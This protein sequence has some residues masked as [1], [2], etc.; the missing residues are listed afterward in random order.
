MFIWF[1][2]LASVLWFGGL[3]WLCQPAQLTR[4][5][6]ARSVIWRDGFFIGLALLL[7]TFLRLPSLFYNQELNPDESQLLT[8]ALTLLRDPVY[9][10][11]VD[12]TSIGPVNSYL[13]LLPHLAGLPIDYIAARL[14]GLLLIS[15]AIF[16]FFRSLLRLVSPVVSRLTLLPVLV[17]FGWTSHADFLHFSSELSSL[18]IITACFLLTVRVLQTPVPSLVGLLGLGLVA[19]LTPYCKLQALPVVG[20]MLITLTVWLCWRYRA[21]AVRWLAAAGVGFLLPTG[22]VFGLACWFG[23]DRYFVDYYFVGNL[24]TYT[25]IYAN[26]PLVQQGFMAKLWHFPFFL[27]QYTD[28]LL[29]ILIN[30]LLV[31]VLGLLAFR[32]NRPRPFGLNF[33]SLLVGLTAAG[34][35]W[36][37]ITPGTEFGHHLLLLV[38]PLGWVMALGLQV[39]AQQQPGS[40]MPFRLA[41]LVGA[42]LLVDML[43]T[44]PLSVS[45]G[46]H[47]ARTI[48][49]RPETT[50]DMELRQQPVTWLLARNRPLVSFPQQTQLHQS[51]VSRVVDTYAIPSDRMA[52][53]GWN[54]QYYVETQLA[55]GISEN[56]S[57][58]SAMPNRM[59]QQYLNRYARELRQN[60]PVVFL[61][62][63]GNASLLLTKP[64]YRHEHFDAVNQ[65]IQQQ[66]RLVTTVDDVRIYV[67]QDRLSVRKSLTINAIHIVKSAY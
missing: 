60:R 33:M 56:H 54:C 41:G 19:G 15:G 64:Q 35:L 25:Q 61:D 59:Q 51:P 27:A 32:R 55:Q 44:D 49:H 65:V 37:T 20:M 52:V 17:F 66:Y 9:G 23:V 3:I 24:S 11:S 38:F 12:G 1:Y 14:M 36:A 6:T 50:A 57:Q 39:V 16:L 31:L 63:V 8:Q 29:F 22:L 10:R 40:Q 18:V 13:L 48:R 30:C 42:L 28:F 67:R 58:R 46:S 26:V 4:P 43:L 21:G 47:L 53:W 5:A 7:L 34:A 62:A 2:Y 45:Y